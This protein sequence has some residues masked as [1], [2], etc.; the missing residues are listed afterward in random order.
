MLAKDRDRLLELFVFYDFLTNWLEDEDCSLKLND[1]NKIKIIKDNVFALMIQYKKTEG[2]EA[3]EAILEE[4]KN[5]RF[6]MILKDDKQDFE[7][8][9]E[10]GLL[11]QAMKKVI[12]DCHQCNFC[13][14]QN[15]KNCEWF[16]INNFLDVKKL[17]NGKKVCPFKND[18]SNIFNIEENI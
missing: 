7:N 11:K 17:D 6:A 10:S 16:T 18:I 14:K 2:L 13:N 15:Y 3:L 1:K 4:S 12:N 5:Y 9:F 8:T